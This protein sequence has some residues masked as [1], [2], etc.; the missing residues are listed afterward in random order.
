MYYIVL[1][2]VIILHIRLCNMNV[3]LAALVD[4]APVGVLRELEDDAVVR[5]NNNNNTNTTNNTNN[6]TN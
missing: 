4:L 1:Y 6:N 2:Y 3:Y 5:P